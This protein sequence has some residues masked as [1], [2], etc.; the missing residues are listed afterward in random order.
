[1][2]CDDTYLKMDGKRTTLVH[3]EAWILRKDREKQKL[4][5]GKLIIG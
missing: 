5:E 3:G 4:E 2:L 1:M